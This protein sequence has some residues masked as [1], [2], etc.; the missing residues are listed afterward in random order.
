MSIT[1]PA[2]SGLGDAVEKPPSP[3]PIVRPAR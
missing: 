1:Q 2:P 3:E